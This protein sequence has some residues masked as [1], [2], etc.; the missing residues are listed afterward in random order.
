[1]KNTVALWRET[2]SKVFTSLHFVLF[3][4]KSVLFIHFVDEPTSWTSETFSQS[5]SFLFTHFVD[6][7]NI[8]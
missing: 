4:K 3:Y 7:W 1:M 2:A 6:K 8:F 5:V